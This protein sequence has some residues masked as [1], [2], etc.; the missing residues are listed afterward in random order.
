VRRDQFR[1]R[2]RIDG[3]IGD[4]RHVVDRGDSDQKPQRKRHHPAEQE[5]A[6]KAQA[7]SPEDGPGSSPAIRHGAAA[8]ASAHAGDV[9]KRR[10]KGAGAGRLYRHG[11]L[12]C[13]RC[14][15]IS[16]QPCP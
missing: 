2:R 13:D 3:R 5:G 16:R 4:G 1:E 10:Q 6:D 15:Q 9:C 8:N 11:A 7:C 12:L 14:R